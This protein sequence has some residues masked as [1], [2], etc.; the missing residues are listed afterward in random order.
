MKNNIQKSAGI[1]LIIGAILMII[2]MVMHPVGGSFQQLLKISTLGIITH[3]IAIFSVP[4]TIFGFWGLTKGFPDQ[5]ALPMAAFITGAIGLFA[6]VLAAAINGL[7]LPFFV[8]RYANASPE[9]LEIVQVVISYSSSL[10]H[11]FDYILIGGLCEAILLWSI[12]IL[13]TGIFP[14]WVSYLGILTGLGFLGALISG[15]VLVDLHGFRIFIFGIVLWILAIGFLLQRAKP[16][17][18]T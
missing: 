9:T 17:A 10:N 6:A 4:F 18:I 16:A 3:T 5:K 11:A 8:E 14:K 12:A 15:F 2:T 13:R 7:T 1:S